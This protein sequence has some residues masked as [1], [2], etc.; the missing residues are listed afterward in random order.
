MTALA[1]ASAEATDMS[2]WYLGFGIGIV[3]VLVVVAL[4]LPILVLAHRIGNQAPPI[5]DG[6]RRAEHHTRA[7]AG[8][9]RT[10]DHADV[11]TA[12]LHRG[13]ERLGG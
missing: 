11:I 4:V 12:G 5:D 13:R 6:L 9:A 10:I 7:L 2:G 8:L 1:Q 3:V